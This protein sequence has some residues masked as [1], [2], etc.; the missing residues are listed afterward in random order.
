MFV[1]VCR[2]ST[3]IAQSSTEAEFYRSAEACR[4]L[5]WIRSFLQEIL[6]EIPCRNFF[7]NNTSTINMVSQECVSERSK[8]RC[9]VSLRNETENDWK[10]R[11]FPYRLTRN[12]CRHIHQRIIGF[13]SFRV[14]LFICF[15]STQYPSGHRILC[16]G[17]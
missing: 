15:G 10:G 17:V 12:V 14:L 11:V 1:A 16:E 8:H 2:R 7:Q 3:L 13:I 5:L 9:K 4:E 6:E